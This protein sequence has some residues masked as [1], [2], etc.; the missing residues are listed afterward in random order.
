[1]EAT[2][3]NNVPNDYTLSWQLAAN[4]SKIILRCERD[5]QVIFSDETNIQS[6]KQR[7]ELAD[8]LVAFDCDRLTVEAKLLAIAG[9]AAKTD[10]RNP[11]T[12][13]E[14][15]SASLESMDSE[16]VAEAADVLSRCPSI[17]EL[18]YEDAQ[19]VGVVGE[20]ATVLTLT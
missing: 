14:A 15:K 16:A 3:M 1:M 13:Y 11:S 8:K 2:N 6:E 12:S 19:A 18:V 5:E 7:R 4:K 9:E 17:L 10:R 20:H